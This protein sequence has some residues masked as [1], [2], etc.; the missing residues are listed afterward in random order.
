M[1]ASR[2]VSAGWLHRITLVGRPRSAC[3]TGVPFEPAKG[4]APMKRLS[5]AVAMGL[6][7]ISSG[8]ALADMAEPGPSHY[9]GA[10]GFR[11][12]EAPVGL[13][14]WFAGQTLGLD[15]GFGY[16]STPSGVGDEKLSGW[17]VDVGIPYRCASWDRVH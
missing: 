11:H 2:N 1:I 10:L 8:V 15:A 17:A 3:P 9:S 7:L 5:V 4:E 16:T 12:I 13:R 14:W 6:L